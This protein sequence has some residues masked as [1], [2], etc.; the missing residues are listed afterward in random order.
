[1][2][3]D[4]YVVVAGMPQCVE[5][6]ETASMFELLQKAVKQAS[7]KWIIPEQWEMRDAEGMLM[8]YSDRIPAERTFLN[9]RVNQ[10]PFGR[11]RARA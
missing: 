8:H 5:I 4:A 1:M 9:M 6:D 2:I 10:G 7:Y 11:N 3:R